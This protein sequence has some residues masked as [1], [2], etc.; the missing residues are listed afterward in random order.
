LRPGSYIPVLKYKEV[1]VGAEGTEDTGEP[2]MSRKTPTIK[3][4]ILPFQDISGSS[5]SSTYARGIPDELAY[6]LMRTEGCSVVSPAYT[7]YFNAHEH[8]LA[9]AMSRVGAQI[10]YGGSVRHEDNHI[11]VTATIVDTAGYQLWTKRFDAEIGSNTLFA[12]EEQIASALAIGFD[13]LFRHSHRT[14]GS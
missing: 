8:D 9:A 7:A 1:L 14:I 12:I 3:I 10:A 5:L 6:T 13:V 2:F 4:A 11:R